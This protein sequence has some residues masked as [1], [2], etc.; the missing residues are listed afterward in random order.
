M[1]AA[2]TA[3]AI[4]DQLRA[5]IA[6]HVRAGDGDPLADDAPRLEYTAEGDRVALRFWGVGHDDD[7]RRPARDLADDPESNYPY[8]AVLDALAEPALAAAVVRLELDGPDSGANGLAPWDLAR[9]AAPSL[10]LPRLTTVALRL[11]DGGDHNVVVTGR[12]GVADPGA[13][14]GRVIARAPALTHLRVPAP[15]SSSWIAALPPG[16]EQLVVQDPWASASGLLGALAGRAPLPALYRIDYADLAFVD[17]GPTRADYLALLASPALAAVRHLTV[18]S[19]RLDDDD[20]RALHAARPAL[21]ILHVPLARPRYVRGPA[22]A[23]R[24]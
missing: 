17:P 7:P 3:T 8:A 6:D 20:R 10:P 1:T 4:L 5:T 23:P 2:T 18:R 16:L 14:L 12:E 22:A 19:H 13:E 21:P 24:R 9:L 11:T 15:A